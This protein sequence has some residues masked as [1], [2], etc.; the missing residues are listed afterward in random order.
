FWDILEQPPGS[1][2]EIEK[3]YFGTHVSLTTDIAGDYLIKLTVSDG[4]S[5]V[6][7]TVTVSFY[8]E[9]VAPSVE[10]I[11]AVYAIQDQTVPLDGSGSYDPNGDVM[12]YQW[13]FVSKPKG[14]NA[15]IDDPLAEVT[16]FYVD[17]PG[18]Y[19]VSLAVSDGELEGKPYNPFYVKA[20]SLLGAHTKLLVNE[21]I[22]P[23][24]L[25]YKERFV[26]DKTLT[27]DE[28]A[29]EYVLGRYTIEAVGKDVTIS[30]ISATDHL[31]LIKPYFRGWSENE[32]VVVKKGES[33]TFE[34]VSPPTNGK[35]TDLS[36]SFAWSLNGVGDFSMQERFSAGYD[37][38]SR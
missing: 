25:P 3:Q 13:F 20:F 24:L 21:D 36:F 15:V 38:T 10:T 33:L 18:I 34:L 28:V 14:S 37:F 35:L 2:P 17:V 29:K 6:S 11:S 31:N 5:V 7:D 26:V 9:N 23:Q 27:D 1:Y 30:N 12:T 32:I 19:A 8:Y 22:E 16:S 4:Y